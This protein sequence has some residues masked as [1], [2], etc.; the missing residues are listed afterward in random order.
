VFKY[1]D[2]V[3]SDNGN[4]KEHIKELTRKDRL[5][6]KKVWGLGEKICRNDCIRRWNLFRYLVQ[7]VMEYGVEIW[8]WEEKTDLEKIMYDYVRWIFGLE[9]CTPRY[10]ISRKLGLKLSVV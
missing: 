6:V 10:L 7:S 8:G 9:F 3:I 5:A 1:L 2:F 4:Y